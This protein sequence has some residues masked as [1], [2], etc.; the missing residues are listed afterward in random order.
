MDNLEKLEKYADT[1]ECDGECD[2]Y[3]PY[4]KC[5]ECAARS[6]L[7]EIGGIATAAIRYI[8]SIDI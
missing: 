5:P 1:D 6:A 4:K 3:S 2:M 8:E 7:N